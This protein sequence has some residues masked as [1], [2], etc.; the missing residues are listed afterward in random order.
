QARL[1]ALHLALGLL[2]AAVESGVEGDAGVN[3]VRVDAGG[4]A[5]AGRPRRVNADGRLIGGAL[6]HAGLLRRRLPPGPLDLRARHGRVAEDVQRRLRGDQF[7]DGVLILGG[8]GRVYAVTDEDEVAVAH[9]LRLEHLDGA[10]DGAREV[11]ASPGG[12]LALEG[13]RG[14]RAVARPVLQH[15]RAVV[16]LER[17]DAVALAQIV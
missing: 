6:R 13:V 4:T 12:E 14:P 8:A 3:V 10:L 17:G 2:A 11:R 7:L 9:G 5:R 1:A 16:E 15:G